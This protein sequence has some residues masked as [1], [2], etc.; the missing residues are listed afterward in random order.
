MAWILYFIYG[1]YF[2][3]YEKKEVSI[4]L[5]IVEGIIFALLSI[6]IV[7]M[8]YM[9]LKYNTVF[10]YYATLFIAY[11]LISCHFFI[12]KF[13]FIERDNKIQNGIINF[14]DSNTY[15]IFLY[16]ILFINIAQ[17]DLISLP[18]SS[19]KKAFLTTSL[20]TLTLI[21]L[22]CLALNFIRKLYKEKII[23]NK[24]T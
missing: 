13:K 7:Y 12:N 8:Q 5:F 20:V 3:K 23:G 22:M 21:L 10:D 11:A 9:S 24:F 19:V 18:N 15:M 16:H 17:Y 4:K 6:F 14:F 2:S 1:M